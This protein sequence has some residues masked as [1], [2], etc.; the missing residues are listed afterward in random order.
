[1]KRLLSLLALLVFAALSCKKAPQGPEQEDPHDEP[2]VIVNSITLD[3]T[4]IHLFSSDRQ[5]TATVDPAD[6]PVKWS[7]SDET[8][9][10]VEQDGW[11]HVLSAG[12]VTITAKAGDKS[13]ACTIYVNFCLSRE[14]TSNCY[15][16]PKSGQYYFKAAKG[17]GTLGIAG[18]SKVEVLWESTG[19]PTAPTKGSVIPGVVFYES[20]PDNCIGILT[21]TPLKDGNAVI[22]AKDAYGNIL[23]SWHIWVCKDYDPAATAQEYKNYSG[24][25]T[26]G[27]MMDRNLGALSVTPG[28]ALANGLLYQWGRKDPF[29]GNGDLAQKKLA[30][31]NPSWPSAVEADASTGTVAYTTKHPTTF[32]T[33][34]DGDWFYAG[35]TTPENS[36]WQSTK[37]NF[38]PC[39]PGWRIPAGGDNGI[40]I[41]AA[42]KR[43]SE[44][45]WDSA[46]R[47]MDLSDM[48]HTSG[49]AW[50]PA[51]G[52]LSYG[53]GALI[54]ASCVGTYWTCTPDDRRA[55]TVTVDGDI[56]KVT[57]NNAAH[58]ASGLSV[59]CQKE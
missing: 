50:Y 32:L 15:I 48:F 3:E 28:D 37:T 45:T 29:P 20:E 57:L 31:T 12:T 25:V 53:K 34:F 22:A 19:T 4:S 17:L 10:T 46:N 16:I 1:M 44:H 47:G 33:T 40:W 51:P 43:F 9:A 56:A 8:V 59:R 52:N 58:R 41:A 54:N 14:G 49:P 7:S 36:R 39:P 27:T 35:N 38:D 21:P 11:V 2:E 42:G 18:I 24:T 5:L 30:A 26:Y 55:V 13:A 6:V 23:W